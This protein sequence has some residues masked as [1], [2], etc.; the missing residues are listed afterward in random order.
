MPSIVAP[1]R[2]W[3]RESGAA[4][5]A[6]RQILPHG[7]SPLRAAAG[8]GVDPV[9]A[10]LL[11]GLYAVMPR[12][13]IAALATS[14]SGRA[15]AEVTAVLE[16]VAVRLGW[17][18]HDLA[19]RDQLIG[20]I[21]AD[22]LGLGPIDCLVADPSITEIM[23][24]GTSHVYYERAGQLFEHPIRFL[25]EQQLRATIDRI[26]SPLGRRLD[27]QNPLVSGRLPGGHRI[28]AVIPP[29]AIDG[30]V[31][32]IRK[33]R[34]R[35]FGLDELASLGA[36]SPEVVELLA[37]AVRA[38]LN[39]AVSGGTGTGKTTL[40]N[41][42]A[43]AISARERIVT[44]EDSA[45]LRF[46]THPHVV[47][48]EA[49]SNNQ[50]GSGA[51]SIR[52]LVVNA[53]R[54]RPDRIVVGE[55]RGEEALEMLQA[56][57]TGHDGSLTTLHANSAAEVPRRLLTMVGYSGLELPAVQVE[58]QIASAIDVVVHLERYRDG[59]RRIAEVAELVLGD[60]G[61]CEVRRLAHF[62]RGPAAL[63]GDTRGNWEILSGGC[64]V[65]A[66][67]ETGAASLEEVARWKARVGC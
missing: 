43:S 34:E 38:R 21:V 49:R 41:A 18:S 37:W 65:D 25:T 10:Q 30:A 6:G 2:A 13:V 14:H 67:I 50:E 46:D 56:M 31:L 27:E 45:E 26:V 11:E 9:R 66:A 39:V 16:D 23:V 44:I 52:D 36:A 33:F 64:V 40:L 62:C 24:N 15:R 60:T 63:S 3:S 19:R 57:N 5:G 8:V 47:R 53:L 4:V 54:M 1:K 35:S 61:S 55:V 59:M 29:I 48:L 28:H 12:E 51:V 58:A 20:E 17:P 32:T 7:V 22:L 42:L